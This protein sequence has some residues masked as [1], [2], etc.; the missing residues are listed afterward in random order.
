M[1]DISLLDD[2]F[3]EQSGYRIAKRRRRGRKFFIFL[4][5]AIAFL[6]FLF[7]SF[8]A[9]SSFIPDTIVHITPGMGLR[10]VSLELR[11]PEC[12]TIQA[13]FRGFCYI[14]MAARS[15]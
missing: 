7:Y 6:L 14:A 9:P 8:S 11:E 2:R 13:C 4:L 12:H 15:A 3:G 5:G 1:D 10:S